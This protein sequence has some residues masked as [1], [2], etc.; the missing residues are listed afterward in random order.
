M[1]PFNLILAPFFGVIG[2]LF[3][4]IALPRAF[5]T[6]LPYNIHNQT[7]KDILRDNFFGTLAFTCALFCIA[8]SVIPIKSW[9]TVIPL[10]LVFIF[11]MS[12]GA[13]LGAYLRALMTY[14]MTKAIQRTNQ[15]FDQSDDSGRLKWYE[16]T[17]FA[18]IAGWVI[19]Y[20]IYVASALLT[21]FEVSSDHPPI[22][23]IIISL[24][25]GLLVAWIVTISFYQRLKNTR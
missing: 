16:F 22:W 5:R 24:I 6:G 17:P 11:V 15:F 10:G 1:E 8:P 18:F 12:C 14:A 7:E 20:L 4:V 3:L 25:F 13:T 9:Y 2:I 23:S 19:Y 21:G